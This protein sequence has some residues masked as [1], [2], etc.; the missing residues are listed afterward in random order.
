MGQMHVDSRRLGDIARVNGGQRVGAA[1]TTMSVPVPL[2]HTPRR[3][4]EAAAPATLAAWFWKS[5]AVVIA[6]SVSYLLRQ[7]GVAAS[8]LAEPF[9]FIGNF[10]L[11]GMV[12]ALGWLIL[13][14]C[15]CLA[16]LTG[17]AQ[18]DDPSA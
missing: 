3:E 12:L 1:I 4:A 15:A 17:A 5:V 11:E 18:F 6:W 8:S 14:A 7:P 9:S 10:A 13:L 2:T 16:V